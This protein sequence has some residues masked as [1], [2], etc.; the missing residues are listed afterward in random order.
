[1]RVPSAWGRVVE[2]E[3]EGGLMLGWPGA[4]ASAWGPG[5]WGQQADWGVLGG[6]AVPELHSVED[7]KTQSTIFEKHA[8]WE[9][10]ENFQKEWS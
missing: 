5:P 3:G 1:M 10:L 4:G 9:F 2:G 7:P 6:G 8:C